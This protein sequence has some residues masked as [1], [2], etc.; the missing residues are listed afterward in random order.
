MTG[1]GVPHMMKTGEIMHKTILFGM[2]AAFAAAVSQ[3]ETYSSMEVD[4]STLLDGDGIRRRDTAS[5]ISVR[6]RGR[7]AP[8]RQEDEATGLLSRDRFIVVGQSLGV[9]G[10]V[11][12]PGGLSLVASQ[13]APTVRSALKGPFRLRARRSPIGRLA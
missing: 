12:T 5:G 13:F 10:G 7:N 2:A 6:T 1:D 3:G 8:A 4:F 9:R 11:G